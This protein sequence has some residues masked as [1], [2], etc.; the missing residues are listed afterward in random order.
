M[1]KSTLER[2]CVRVCALSFVRE[3]KRA[4]MCMCACGLACLCVCARLKERERKRTTKRVWTGKET[5]KT[6]Q[7]KRDGENSIK[8]KENT[9]KRESGNIQERNRKNCGHKQA[10]D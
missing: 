2:V 1:C 5:Q 10:R 4:C 7:H 3:T 6:S 8:I 9:K